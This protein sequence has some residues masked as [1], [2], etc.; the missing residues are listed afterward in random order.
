M[1][2]NLT[3]RSRIRLCPCTTVVLRLVGRM[4]QRLTC[5]SLTMDL[6]LVPTFTGALK[7]SRCKAA[8]ACQER[9]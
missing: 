2:P 8:Q 7:L 4:A 6:T 9:H 3:L 1:A 5:H